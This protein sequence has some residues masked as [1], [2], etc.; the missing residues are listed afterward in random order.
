MRR[1]AE[2]RV[3]ASEAREKR[4]ADLR[5][6]SS[7][8]FLFARWPLC[9]GPARAL[10][11]APGRCSWALAAANMLSFKAKR[12]LNVQ[13]GCT[14]W[15]WLPCERN[16]QKSSGKKHSADKTQRSGRTCTQTNVLK[17]FCSGFIPV[18]FKETV[19]LLSIA[20]IQK[21]RANRMRSR[22]I[23]AGMVHRLCSLN[24]AAF[25]ARWASAILTGAPPLILVSLADLW[26]A[27]FVLSR[28]GAFVTFSV[29][30]TLPRSIAS[31]LP[32]HVDLIVFVIVPVAEIS[33]SFC[34]DLPLALGP[35]SCLFLSCEDNI[36]C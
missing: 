16:R 2:E 26:R 15:L 28:P 10:A 14:L 3:C 5:V 22:S 29:S 9:L 12:C 8:G 4:Q 18:F 27:I 19:D 20:H 25:W 23:S 13:D 1:R 7:S 34:A 32:P 35:A 6:A 31:K 24:E 21:A 33:F 30:A 17:V 11:A 36:D